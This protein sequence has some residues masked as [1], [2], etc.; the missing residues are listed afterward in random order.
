MF[1]FISITQEY[2]EILEG[3]KLP[4][5]M[6][7]TLMQNSIIK[8]CALLQPLYP[9]PELM[10]IMTNIFFEQNFDSFQKM[11]D[12]LNKV[13]DTLGNVDMYTDNT[14][15]INEKYAQADNEGIKTTENLERQLDT[16]QT[17]TTDTE[18]SVS[19]YNESTY[20]PDRKEDYNRNLSENSTDTAENTGNSER[21]F[22]R[23]STNE[24]VDEFNE[25]RRGN[26]GRYSFQKLITD[27]IKLYGNFNIYEYIA[28][29]YEDE[30]ML[31]VY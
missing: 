12:T 1:N 13:Y 23:N 8:R 28:E 7:M 22:S 15:N 17:G 18:F 26:D 4:S 29:K 10:T 16:T 24:N 19:A 27:T 5:G 31:S 25:H 21:N 11:W 30:L 14:R 9:E 20:Q 6:D 3:F 2:P